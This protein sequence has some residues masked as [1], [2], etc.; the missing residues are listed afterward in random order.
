MTF[1]LDNYDSFV[2][3]RRMRPYI[4]SSAEPTPTARSTYGAHPTRGDGAHR[5]ALGA[6]VSWGGGG[7]GPPPPPPLPRGAVRRE[8]AQGDPS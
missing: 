1:V 7:G 5:S 3:P 4:A 2:T 8:R 6:I